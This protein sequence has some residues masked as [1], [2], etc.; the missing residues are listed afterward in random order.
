MATANTTRKKRIEHDDVVRSF[1]TRLREL[2]TKR[3]LSQLQLAQR[4]H[5]NVNYVG[6]L[7][8]ATAAP[9][10][11]LVGRLAAAL[12]VS[13]QELL[14]S[15]PTNTL[16]LLQEQARRRFDSILKRADAPALSVLNPW[17]VL[18]DDA[19]IRSE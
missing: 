1:A 3:G 5:V 2:R 10:I 12:N 18:L 14:Q 16:P 17:L 11:D 15:A 7:E 8:R 13:I 4:A 9:G 6:R 19:L